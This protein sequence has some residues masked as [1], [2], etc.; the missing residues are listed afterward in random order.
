MK[1][2]ILVTVSILA[3]GI[4]ILV[5]NYIVVEMN[6]FQISEGKPIIHQEK[7]KPAV[8][9]IDIQEGTTGKSSTSD[10]FV[11]QSERLI[12]VVNRI[13]DSSARNNI[14]VIYVKN[15]ISNPL[16][17]ILN[18][19]MAKGSPGAELDSRVRIV[20]GY[21]LNKDKSDAFSNSLLD[22]ILI[23]ND[24]NKLVFTGLDLARCVHST[25][26][27]AANRDYDICLISD[28]LISEYPDS[29]KQDMLDKFKQRGFEI[30][31]SDEYLQS[32]HE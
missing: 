7:N 12:R 14:P 30:L 4:L 8:L 15:E 17:N 19:S 2:T 29:L 9:V 10:V 11:L 31:T 18:N 22:S 16:I 24:V 6:A 32:P 20:S 26:L 27:A 23:R 25:I 3:L 5:V 1:K 13:V 28:A 21:I